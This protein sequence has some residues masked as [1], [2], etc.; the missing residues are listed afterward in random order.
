MQIAWQA[1]NSDLVPGGLASYEILYRI[2]HVGFSPEVR[3]T[4]T[5]STNTTFRLRGLEE[6]VTYWISV[7]AHVAVH[8]ENDW[9]PKC[10]EYN[11][12]TMDDGK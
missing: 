2:V 7:R 11:V 10:A 12:T 5:W 8:G 9:R 3:V 4:K 6:S 1:L